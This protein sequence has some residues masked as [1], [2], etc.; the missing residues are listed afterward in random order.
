MSLL[1]RKSYQNGL[2]VHAKKTRFD[3]ACTFCAGFFHGLRRLC[4]NRLLDFLLYNSAMSL[5]SEDVL[6]YL[7]TNPD[8]FEHH[9]NSLAEMRLR[10]PYGGRAVS[11][12][13]RQ[14]ELL[15]DKIKMLEL[16]M[17]D[18]FRHGNENALTTEKLQRWTL[19]MLST[20]HATDIPDRI[21]RE[22]QHHFAVPQA[23]IRLWG[24]SSLFAQSSYTQ[25]V[26]EDGKVF[27][28]SLT[29]CYCGTN[30]DL[31][32]AQWLPQPAQ[33]SSIALLPLRQAGQ[34]ETAGAFGL[35]VL[36][37]PDP[38]RFEAGMGTEFLQRI[39]DIASAALSR[40]L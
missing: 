31:E 19:A 27:A 3:Q 12:Q 24:I 20:S 30:V 4:H 18:M 13:E 11:L 21:V 26:T 36:A 2:W 28:S 23:A 16:R 8:F 17:L 1:A 15:R 6:H 33:A 39:A 10:S 7:Q 14:A 22:L 37:S 35:L 5:N 34:A 40:L 9:A 25:G 32:A 29:D 38:Q